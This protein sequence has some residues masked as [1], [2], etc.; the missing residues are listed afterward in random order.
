MVL[1][2]SSEHRLYNFYNN[3]PFSARHGPYAIPD[4]RVKIHPHKGCIK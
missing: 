1:N 4:A 2:L 3:V